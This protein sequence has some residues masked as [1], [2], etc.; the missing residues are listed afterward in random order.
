MSIDFKIDDRG[1]FIV[2]TPPLHKRLKISFVHST[3]PVLRIR[4]EQG[5]ESAVIDSDKKLCVKFA[6][7]KGQETMNRKI[8]TVSDIDEL[9][10]RIMMRLRTEAGE[11]RLLPS[12]GSYVTILKHEDIMSEQTHAELKSAILF[13][14]SDIVQNPTVVIVPKRKSGPFFCQNINA[15]IYQNDILLYTLSL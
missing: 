12:T 1:D 7:C 3:H 10:Q 4:F 5:Q 15:Y 11:M 2:S 8:S 13:A 6:T 9:R 14:I